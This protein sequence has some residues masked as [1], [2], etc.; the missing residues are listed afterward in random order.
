ME[1]NAYDWENRRAL[2]RV[3]L[4]IYCFY[5]VA[6]T[7][8]SIAQGWGSWVPTVVI[9]SMILSCAVVFRRYKDYRFRAIFVSC[10]TWLVFSLYGVHTESYFGTL[11]TMTGMVILLGMYCLPEIMYISVICSTFLLLFHGFVLKTIHITPDLQGAKLVLQIF[12]VY[13]TEYIT[14]YL[15]RVQVDSNRKQQKV[16]ESLK[17][18][19]AS[20][21]DFVANVSHEIRTPVNTI[22]GMSEMILREQI[23]SQVRED[24]Y[25]IQ[26]AGRNLLAVVSDILDFSEL[27]SGKLALVEESYNITSTINDIMNMAIARNSEKNLELVVDCD[28]NLPSGMVGDEQK[29][30]RAVM[31]IVD[32]AIKFTKEGGIIIR[33]SSRKEEY[34]VNLLISVEDTGIGMD[35]LNLERLFATY[36]QVDTKRNRQEGGIGLGLAISQAIVELMGG[37]ISVKS[38][39]GKGSEVQITV[40]QKVIDETPIVSLKEPEKVRVICLLGL[41]D[42]DYAVIRNG[43]EQLIMHVVNQLGIYCRQCRNRS[44]FKRRIEKENYTH[45]FISRNEYQHDPAYFE[46]LSTKMKIVLVMDRE[47][48]GP[49]G[50]KML[51]VYKPLYALSIVAALNGERVVQNVAGSQ[52]RSGR[53]V[54]PDACILVVDDNYMNLRVVEGLLKPYQIKVFSAD[55]GEE[56]LKKI[57]TMDYDFVFMDHMMPEMDGVETLHRIRKK[58]G[59]YFQTVPIIAL[60]AN[61]IGGARE[62]FL[63]EGFAD[64]VAKPVELSVLERVLKQYIPENKIKEIEKVEADPEEFQEAVPEEVHK[65]ETGFSIKGID[66]ER[67]LLYSGENEEDYLDILRIYYASGLKKKEE[68]QETFEKKDWDNYTIL[69]HGLKSLSMSIG[70]VTLSEM[71]RKLEEAGN[72]KNETYIRAHTEETLTAY[73]QVLSAIRA[74]SKVFPEQ[75]SDQERSN[76]VQEQDLSADFAELSGERLKEELAKLEEELAT[77]EQDGVETLI[78]EL[79][80]YSFRGQPLQELLSPIR[81]KVK[82]FD[83]MG[84]GEELAMLEEKAR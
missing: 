21:D 17:R 36:N 44:E 38:V 29:I 28:A 63:E 16:I 72:D 42:Y 25:D 55:S 62:M 1:N 40:P 32:N 82:V 15:V 9:I 74:N 64:F 19:E 66:V 71:A 24:V 60:T 14:F 77:L 10:M 76:P 52:Y 58:P 57:E 49:I 13:L 47:Q 3:I 54:A 31:S 30:R 8:M 43:Y 37:F 4:A 48:G 84:A 22:C 50:G 26:M 27:A 41:D 23:S 81:E 20:K 70:A 79:S 45:V 61:A 56:A 73:E 12:A 46:E 51:H 6:V 75:E 78:K 59:K 5:G 39:L 80:G 2:E 33:I 53:F 11:S 34:G 65:E 69:V 7:I 83:F 67:G 68:I 18:A 35:E